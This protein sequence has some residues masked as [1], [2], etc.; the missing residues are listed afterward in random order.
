MS[1][2]H[3]KSKGNQGSQKQPQPALFET[4][5]Y[6]NKETQEEKTG[7]AEIYSA[8]DAMNPFVQKIYNV[9]FRGRASA[10]TA[11]FTCALVVFS[12]LLWKVASDATDTSLHT[13]RAFLSYG[14][15]GSVKITGGDD[16]KI[17][18]G[19]RFFVNW[20]NSGT[21]PTKTAITESNIAVTVE[22]PQTANFDTLQH[23]GQRAI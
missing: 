11:I 2:R 10:W 19:A 15:M 7:E 14:G 21:T 20:V 16:D 18:T 22:T 3:P 8:E 17:L 9:V 5:P 6:Q 4:N 23:A 1:R 13:Q 12:G